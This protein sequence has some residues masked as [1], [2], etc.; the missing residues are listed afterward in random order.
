MTNKIVILDDS[1]ILY[2]HYI[3]DDQWE[4]TLAFPRGGLTYLVSNGTI[5]FYAYEDYFY[6]NCLI[7]MQLP[8]YIVDEYMHI[9][10][11]YDDLDELVE[12]L[13]RIFPTN[14]M[15]AQLDKY[16]KKIDADLL[17]QPIGDYALKSDIPDV[18]EF[19]T[20]D[21]LVDA[22]EDYYTKDEVDTLL[23]DK[24]NKDDVYTKDEADARFQPIGD[25]LTSA[26]TYV[27]SE[28]DDKLDDKLDASA[29]TPCDLS[30]YYTKQETSSKTQ[31]DT[32]LEAKADVD[33]VY[34]KEE[35]DSIFQVK[36]IAGR[37]ITISGNVISAAGGSGGTVDA[38]TKEESDARYQPIGDYV[39]ETDLQNTL[40]YYATKQ[41]VLNQNYVTSSQVNQYITNLQEQIN[42]LQDAL[43]SCCSGSPTPTTEYRWI[44]LTNPSDYICS[45]T[46]KYEKQQKQQSTDGGITW[47]NV[48]PSEYRKGSVIETG[49]T[50][51]GEE[52]SITDI[53]WV[54]VPNEYMCKDTPSP[55]CKYKVLKL[56]YSYDSGTTWV[57]SNPLQT[58]NGT[59]ISCYNTDCGYIEP[60]YRWTVAPNEYLC[61][62]TSKYE[63]E[64]Y[65]V[66]YDS[67]TTWERVVPEETRRGNL[68]ETMSE[69]CGFVDGTKFSALYSDGTSYSAQCDGNTSIGGS[70]TRA[71]ST[72]FTAMTSAATGPC[73]TSVGENAFSGCTSLS[74][75]TLDA[76]TT[77]IANHAFD[78]CRNLKNIN[79]DN[80]THIDYSAFMHCE[81]LESVS[82]PRARMIDDGVFRYCTSL[83]SVYIGSN[84]DTSGSF[85][86]IGSHAFFQCTNLTSLTINATTPPKIGTNILYGADNCIIY[87][88]RNS[89][90]TYKT[91]S[92]WSSYADR[93][94]AK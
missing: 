34:T 81:N 46:T 47:E 87:V 83:V 20:T 90:N 51:C 6:R 40:N 48:V 89:V 22:L 94:R 33:D 13:D 11:E 49:S 92:G 72:S 10:G 41:W 88:P 12:I 30:N 55:Y 91:A 58:T 82:L 71:H 61:S 68:I 74:S 65:E 2:E 52:P 36:L 37:N 17:Y 7:S 26:D 84:I 77:G 76:N 38:Y 69:D 42:S 73:V 63:K 3:S 62:G 15:D 27:K 66:S 70:V 28:I 9:D 60:Q 75:V 25:Y 67:G 64:Y 24:A 43:E 85:K 14:D 57:D 5:K 35:S 79:L 32:A 29:Y 19:V 80:V 53:R 31:I 4:K 54:E 50:D 18:S 1:V 93:I 39:I 44:T 86:A 8:I 16:L 59:L 56:Q 45:G 21:E 23:D 78:E